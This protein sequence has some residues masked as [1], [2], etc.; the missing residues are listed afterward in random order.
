MPMEHEFWNSRWAAKQTAFH[1]GKPNELLAAHVS[2]LG[3]RV[4]VPLCGKSVDLAFLA[5]QGHEVV[6]VE[7]VQQAIDEYFEEGGDRRVTMICD[8]IFNITPERVGRFDAIYDRA[9]LVALE[10]STR[11]RYV[12]AC[13]ALLTPS[14]TT[15]HFLIGFGYDQTITAGPPWSVDEAT[16]RTLFADRTIEVLQTHQVPAPGRL[17]QAG[18][19]SIDET[20]YFIQ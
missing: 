3:K 20:A 4:L 17:G 2:R 5:E 1:E 13:R 19:K 12:A 8:D 11:E 6:G 9:A 16:V 18:L 7:F 14:A 15:G 10:P